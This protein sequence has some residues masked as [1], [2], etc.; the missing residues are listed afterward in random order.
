MNDNIEE[1]DN[2]EENET[3]KCPVCFKEISPERQASKRYLCE[4]CEMGRAT[5]LLLIFC[6]PA[7]LYVMW[8]KADWS[9]K[10]KNGVT[11]FF[12]L[13]VAIIAIINLTASCS[14]PDKTKSTSSVT[15]SSTSSVTSSRYGSSLSSSR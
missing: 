3:Y 1:D 14:S 11:T 15:S 13:V 9:K 5:V 10:A 8:T 12:V 2:I 7:G 4:D 6:F